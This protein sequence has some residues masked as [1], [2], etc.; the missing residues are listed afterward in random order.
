MQMISS[1][2]L[3][4]WIQIRLD[5]LKNWGWDNYISFSLQGFPSDFLFRGL[6]FHLILRDIQ[7]FRGHFKI[8]CFMSCTV[9]VNGYRAADQLSS[10]VVFF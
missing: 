1:E 10:A 7:N 5:F 2:C 6:M 8:S 4:G 9:V 3:T